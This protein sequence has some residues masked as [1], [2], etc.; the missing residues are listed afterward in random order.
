MVICRVS[1]QMATFHA[2]WP[3]TDKRFENEPVH[4]AVFS[5]VLRC[6]PDVLVPAHFGGKRHHSPRNSVAPAC[7][8]DEFTV[9]APH[10]PV[11]ADLVG[12]FISED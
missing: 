2:C 11:A 10:S 6:H 4:L 9:K 1:V 7:R 8:V 5:N 12:T 3:G